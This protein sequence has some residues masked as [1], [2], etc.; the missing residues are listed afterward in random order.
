MI[1]VMRQINLF[2]MRSKKWW[3]NWGREEIERGSYCDHL[4]STGAT[5]TSALEYNSNLKCQEEITNNIIQQSLSA[6]QSEFAS[7]IDKRLWFPSSFFLF[8]FFLVAFCFSLSQLKFRSWFFGMA[9][10]PLRLNFSNSSMVL[11][12]ELVWLPK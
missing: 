6:N 7:L 3:E 5:G 9:I 12:L 4:R 8:R 1:D 10:F 11:L 2:L